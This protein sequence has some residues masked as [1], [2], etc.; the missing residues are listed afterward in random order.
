MEV[1]AARG[2]GSSEVEQRW[3]R[4]HGQPGWRSARAATVDG[5][6]GAVSRCDDDV[7]DRGSCE[8]GRWGGLYFGPSD[9]LRLHVASIWRE[10]S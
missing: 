2:H 9:V 7:V 4:W 6:D 10:S 1:A 8:L 5:G 3:R